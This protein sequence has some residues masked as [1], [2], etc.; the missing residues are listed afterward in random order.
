[1]AKTKKPADPYAEGMVKHGTPANAF[2]EPF[3]GPAPGS[4]KKKKEIPLP[5]RRLS[6]IESMK[7]L[8]DKVREDKASQEYGKKGSRQ[9]NMIENIQG[10]KSPTIRFGKAV[11]GRV[12]EP[13]A[14]IMDALSKDTEPKEKSARPFRD[15]GM[16]DG[17][18]IKGKTR[19]KMC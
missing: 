13:F 10:E 2:K 9:R 3:N 19:G 6:E 5:N 1:M 4:R 17:A 12:A 8:D 18:A 14:K 16:I 11:V 7:K 15:G